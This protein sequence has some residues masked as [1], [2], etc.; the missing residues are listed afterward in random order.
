[1]SPV[2][3][4]EDFVRL[5]SVPFPTQE[6]R[7]RPGHPSRSSCATRSSATPAARCSTWPR[8]ACSPAAISASEIESR[9]RTVLKGEVRVYV[10]DGSGSMLGPRARMRDAIL[11]AELATLIRRLQDQARTSRVALFY[12]YFNHGLGPVH[13]V[14]AV[15]GALNQIRDV[16]ATP[17][18][19]GTNIERALLASLEQVKEA[20]DTDPDL[21]KAQIVL[22]TD[23]M[24]PV[25]EATIERAR[26]ELGELSL[27]ISVVALGEENRALR[28][29]VAKQRARGVRAFYHFLP[30]D[31]IEEMTRG[32][33][34]DGPPIHLPPVGHGPADPSTARAELEARVGPLLEEL[35][36]L[37]RA[38]NTAA[39][40]S[41]DETDREQRLER[42]DGGEEHLA[43][44][45]ERAS[46]EALHR[47]HRALARRF[48]RWFPAP[49][50]PRPELSAPGSREPAAPAPEHGTIERDDL[51]SV[52]VLLATIAEVVE[53]IEGSELGRQADAIDLLERMLPDARLSPARY[54]FVLQ[55]YPEHVAAGLE[56]VHAAVR[57]GMWWRIEEPH[58]RPIVS[59]R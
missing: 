22:I 30:D 28:Q 45:G 21:A 20:R 6:D 9:T 33:I 19:G 27:G 58:R 26:S 46:L 25:R 7:A 51:E 55:R 4:R 48:A 32:D 37:Q 8:A 52:L 17:R 56:A 34:D 23:G 36:D 42:A 43:G 5:T 39:L 38:R 57:W 1:M 53:L 44:E 29:L 11:V 59:P 41:L 54:H 12:R 18:S 50:D 40:C 3:V 31:Y 15:S 24:A 49:R 16:L 35:A 47:D 14:D 13:R 10:L 2:R